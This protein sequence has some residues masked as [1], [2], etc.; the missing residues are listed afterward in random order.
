M[1][2]IMQIT[3][4]SGWV[5]STVVNDNVIVH[6]VAAWALLDNGDVVGLVPVSG[7]FTAQPH[8]KLVPAPEGGNY[9]LVQKS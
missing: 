7:G 4:C 3:P 1:P 5:H 8:A 9:S 6:Q 2:K